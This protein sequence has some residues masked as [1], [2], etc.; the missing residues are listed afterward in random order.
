MKVGDK[1]RIRGNRE[2]KIF[3][4][5]KLEGDIATI[6][7]L[8]DKPSDDAGLASILSAPKTTQ[9]RTTDLIVTTSV[10][11]KFVTTYGRDWYETVLNILENNS[12]RYHAKVTDRHVPIT[13]IYVE[14][15]KLEKV[16]EMYNKHYKV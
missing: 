9:K 2:L 1:V 3:K 4:I 6:Q 16:K 7:N 13:E 11:T 15:R 8:L 10:P 5:V 12:I 14:S